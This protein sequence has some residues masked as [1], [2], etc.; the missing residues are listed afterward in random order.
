MGASSVTPAPLPWNS[1][2]TT[3]LRAQ[4]QTARVFWAA[5]PRS[6]QPTATRQDCSTLFPLNHILPILRPGSCVFSPKNREFSISREYSH[7]NVKHG[8]TSSFF[9][10]SQL[11]Y[12]LDFSVPQHR[13]EEA[14]WESLPKHCEDC[15]WTA[16]GEPGSSAA[17]PA[18][19][20][21]TGFHSPAL[22]K[23]SST[24]TLSH[25]QRSAMP[26]MRYGCHC[27][28]VE[29]QNV[30]YLWIKMF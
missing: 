7:G 8:R 28:R 24:T 16:R 12:L 21:S 22:E 23:R 10:E 19:Q 11:S 1:P 13:K 15:Q 26:A 14:A 25:H 17:H 20:P 4:S 9:V 29:P 18:M 5:V 6:A 2:L 27:E 30:L 3:R